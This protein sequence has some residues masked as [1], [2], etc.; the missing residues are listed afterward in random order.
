MTKP[1]LWTEMA[2][3]KDHLEDLLLHHSGK[4]VLIHGAE[5]AGVFDTMA[6]AYEAGIQNW[7]NVPMLI[8]QVRK[9]VTIETVPA[10]MHGVVRALP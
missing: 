10:L 8:R 3:F 1:V 9:E 5:L 4:F 6:A 2:Y 7:G